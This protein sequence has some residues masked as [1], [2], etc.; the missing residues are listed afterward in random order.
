MLKY[1]SFYFTF[2]DFGEG[3]QREKLYTTDLTTKE[4]SYTAEMGGTRDGTE[5]KEV[6]RD[7]TG[8]GTR[9]TGLGV[10]SGHGRRMDLRGRAGVPGVQ[11]IGEPSPGAGHPWRR[12]RRS[13]PDSVPDVRRHDEGAQVV[14]GGGVEG[15]ARHLAPKTPRPQA[16]EAV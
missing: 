11:G 4:R 13:G 5:E 16:H 15:L 2:I 6:G 10:C 12:L 3:A 9:G 8:R 14:H 1:L 7:A